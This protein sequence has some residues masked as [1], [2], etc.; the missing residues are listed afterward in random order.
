MKSNASNKPF[1]ITKEDW[2]A[3]AAASPEPV[4]DPECPYDPNDPDAVTTYWKDA[5]LT[6]GG[7]PSAVV[8]ALERRR[9]GQRGAQ[10]A[11]VKVP[12]TIRLDARVV[13]HFKATG[14]GWQTRINQALLDM[15]AKT[16][17]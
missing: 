17:P 2:E 13:K 8:D 6:D 9:Q 12:I 10:K 7:G 14:K 5:V 3:L 4:D 15:V 16:R 1:P 11:P